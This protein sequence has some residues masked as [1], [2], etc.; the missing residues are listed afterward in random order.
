MK[1]FSTLKECK[2]ANPNAKW[3]YHD[4]KGIG[5][6]IRWYASKRILKKAQEKLSLQGYSSEAAAKMGFGI[7]SL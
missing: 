1:Y 5:G 7:I 6:Q 2:A 3:F 4:S